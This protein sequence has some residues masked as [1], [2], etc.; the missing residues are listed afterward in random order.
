MV[1][2]LAW[3]QILNMVINKWTSSPVVFAA[4]SYSDAQYPSA[5]PNKGKNINKEL[6]QDYDKINN[7]SGKLL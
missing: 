1:I 7:W 4:T 5:L 2:E 6:R 3:Y